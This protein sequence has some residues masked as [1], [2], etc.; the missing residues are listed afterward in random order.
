MLPGPAVPG[1]CFISIDFRWG[2]LSTRTV[3]GSAR[4]MIRADGCGQPATI[5]LLF[6]IL[7][8]PHRSANQLNIMEKSARL[9]YPGSPANAMTAFRLNASAFGLQIVKSE[10]KRMGWRTS[11]SC[12]NF[13]HIPHTTFLPR[14]RLFLTEHTCALCSTSFVS[15]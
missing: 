8:G 3:L 1:C 6:I 13:P 10:K 5:S 14:V 7:L 2:K 11:R 15:S 4:P 12:S 9:S